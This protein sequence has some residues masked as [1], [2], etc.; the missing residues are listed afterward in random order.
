MEEPMTDHL[1]DVQRYD[2]AASA[3]SVEK[4]VRHLGIALRSRDSSLVSCSDDLEL[5][6]VKEKWCIKKLGVDAAAADSAVSKACE[7]MR[8]DRNKARVTFYYLCAKTLGKLE[9]L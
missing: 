8:G 9:A 6:R 5:D 1:A 7:Q 4:I 2:A 3:E